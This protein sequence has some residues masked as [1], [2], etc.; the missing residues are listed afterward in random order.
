MLLILAFQDTVAEKVARVLTA[1]ADKVYLES[2]QERLESLVTNTNFAKYDYILALGEY[3]GRDKDTIRIETEC[4]SQFRNDKQDLRKLTIPY[5]FKSEPPF[6]L[7]NGIGNS[8]CNL[9]SYQI[10]SRV[11]DARTTFLH[12]PKTFNIERAVRAIDSQL[13]RLVVRPSHQN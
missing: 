4:S 3:T 1:P 9:V 13:S 5:F 6:R 8:W 12:I 7:A 2:S 11:L 10:L